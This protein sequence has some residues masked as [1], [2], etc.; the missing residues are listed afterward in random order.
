MYVGNLMGT[1]NCASVCRVLQ[2]NRRSEEEELAFLAGQQLLEQEQEAAAKAAAKKA[3][4][5][6]QK[7][8]KQSPQQLQP[9]AVQQGKE[10]CIDCSSQPSPECYQSHTFITNAVHTVAA[11]PVCQYCLDK[12]VLPICVVTTYYVP[13]LYCPGTYVSILSTVRWMQIWQA[14]LALHTKS[15]SSAMLLVG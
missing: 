1:Y 10:M 12:C 13:V 15:L 4:K 11:S 5:L 14:T 3:K 9:S 7:A 6:R 2:A 8:K